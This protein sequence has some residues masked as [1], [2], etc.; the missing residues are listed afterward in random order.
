MT[1]SER[2]VAAYFAAAPWEAV[3]AVGAHDPER[4]NAQ[5]CVS[6]FGASI[7]EDMARLL[8][9]LWKDNFTHELVVASGTLACTLLTE[10]QLNLL[11]PLG[12]RSGRGERGPFGKLA[13]L[14]FAVSASGDPYFPGGTGYVDCGVIDIYDLGDCT[15]FLVAVREDVR[16]SAAEPMTWS[17]ARELAGDDF[18]LRYQQK[19]ARDAQHAR[20]LMRWMAPS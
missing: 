19:F 20:T 14:E 10:G 17:R 12:L 6:V 9:L 8:V 4:V 2:P 5:I 3:C 16:L 7:V 13:A 11:E 18:R 15:A 1:E